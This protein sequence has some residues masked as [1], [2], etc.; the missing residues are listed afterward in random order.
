V[1]CLL[2]PHQE[3]L[4]LT[5]HLVEIGYEGQ[6]TLYTYEGVRYWRAVYEEEKDGDKNEFDYW[7]RIRG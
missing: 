3:L 5:E 2:A 6:V 7:Q 1:T 4:K